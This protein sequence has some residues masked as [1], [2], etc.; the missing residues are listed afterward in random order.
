MAKT[1][2]IFKT[3]YF[4]FKMFPFRDALKLPVHLAYR[5]EVRGAR[6]GTIVLNKTIPGGVR[7][8]YLKYPMKSGRGVWTLLRVGSPE[9]RLCL[10]GEDI[11]IYRGCS[12]ILAYPESCMTIGD[13]TLINQD[14]MLYCGNRVDIGPHSSIG[15]SCQIYDSN[16]HLTYDQRT[17][18]IADRKKSVD[19]GRN[20]WIA[21]HC[22]VAAGAIVPPYST[23]AAGSLV[24]K[25]FSH[26]ATRGNFFA[27]RPAAFRR[28]GLYRILNLAEEQRLSAYFKDHVGG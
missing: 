20:V 7:I 25:D 5:V 23:V 24:N 9:A 19:I 22:T 10:G 13:D 28:D 8:G 14:V 6:R 12:I 16:F 2:D 4:N 27:G 17:R 1:T 26:V 21:N 15:W 18:T 3:V 11:E